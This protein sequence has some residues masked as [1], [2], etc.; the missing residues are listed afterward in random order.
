[1]LFCVIDCSVKVYVFFNVQL[2]CIHLIGLKT[3]FDVYI[4]IVIDQ[5]GFGGGFHALINFH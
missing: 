4:F 5:Y 1:M 3:E 2:F